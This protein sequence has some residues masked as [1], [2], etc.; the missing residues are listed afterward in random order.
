MLYLIYVDNVRY[1][2]T[3]HSLLACAIFQTDSCDKFDL[4]TTTCFQLP[5][6]SMF[7]ILYRWWMGYEPH[8]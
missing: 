8:T 3:F 2:M 1:N 4:H 5:L 7:F 6:M